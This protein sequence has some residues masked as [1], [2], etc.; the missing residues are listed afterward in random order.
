VV[1]SKE[2]QEIG[3]RI[4]FRRW[5]KNFHEG[6]QGVEPTRQ[7][8]PTDDIVV[9]LMCGAYDTVKYV[10]YRH[11]RDGT[12]TPSWDV[13]GSY[14]MRVQPGEDC[15]FCSE[16]GSPYHTHSLLYASKTGEIES[17]DSTAT[18]S[19]LATASLARVPSR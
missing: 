3:N 17:D 19:R 16:I 5:T 1:V 12:Q 8:I 18:L 2:L 9:T 7:V 10:T 15:H 14:F 11:I 6:L 13:T 4:T